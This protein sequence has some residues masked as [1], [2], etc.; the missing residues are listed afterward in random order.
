MA[1]Q[2]R[3]EVVEARGLRSMEMFSK[4]DPYVVIE[5]AGQKLKTRTHT[6]GGKTPKWSQVRVVQIS[7]SHKF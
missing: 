3:L 4:Q 6:N 7:I 1:Q 5:V 2:F